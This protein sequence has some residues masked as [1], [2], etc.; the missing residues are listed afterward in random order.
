MRLGARR[1]R[2]SSCTMGLGFPG[3]QGSWSC[4][5][6][7][8]FQNCYSIKLY[9]DIDVLSS[10]HE[11]RASPWSRG[12]VNVGSTLSTLV[13]L[14]SDV[15]EAMSTHRHPSTLSNRVLGQINDSLRSL[16][17][18]R[19]KKG[20]LGEQHVLGCRLERLEWDKADPVD[21]LAVLMRGE[22]VHR[23]RS[24]QVLRKRFG[25]NK[26]VFVL[27]HDE[28][29][30]GRRPLL[31]T[32]VSLSHK[33]PSSM[34]EIDTNEDTVAYDAPSVATF[35]SINNMELGLKGIDLGQGAIHGVVHLLQKEFPH[36]LQT[37]A[38][39]SPIPGFR[40]WVQDILWSKKRSI[41]SWKLFDGVDVLV[42]EEKIC[43]LGVAYEG[44]TEDTDI[45]LLSA[46]LLALEKHEYAQELYNYLK[47]PLERLCRIYM[48]KC[49]D[50]VG[51]FHMDN[52]AILYKIHH[53]ADVSHQGR[54]NSYGLM[55]NYLYRI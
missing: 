49:I 18:D 7:R 34:L 32:F 24:L 53:N 43:S 37:C 25:L 9:D 54:L 5:H 29:Y 39:L 20:M 30:G 48:A 3:R 17:T 28:M 2:R 19:L 10:S 41:S 44:T 12:N 50:P 31:A 47:S 51:G 46:S 21:D 8:R 26:R 23:M 35:Y 36:S 52:G 27:K 42:L 16:I 38:T 11:N 55:A 22:Q 40:S 4:I 14:R 33:I 13:Q 45:S 15:L 1:P 6:R